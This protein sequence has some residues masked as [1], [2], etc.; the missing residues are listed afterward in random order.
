MNKTAKI[1]S[2]VVLIIILAGVGYLYYADTG[3]AP[4]STSALPGSS[5]A[6]TSP[7]TG[8]ERD[9]T[10]Q[11]L[12]RLEDIDINTEFLSAQVFTSFE[13]FG[14]AIQS[15]PVGR[16][17]P[18]TPPQV[19]IPATITENQADFSTTSTQPQQ[20]DSN[21][22]ANATTTTSTTSIDQLPSTDSATTTGSATTTTSATSS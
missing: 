16:D 11:R 2:G 4:L 21:N 22:E 14:I 19:Q 9:Q 5:S 7:A 18:F 15:Q 10:L 6:T 1:I 8:P 20:S 13:N 12:N 3:G 17:N